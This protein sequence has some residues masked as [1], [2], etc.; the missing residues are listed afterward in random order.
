MND[1]NL[2]VMV[3]A[4]VTTFSG[5]TFSS[6]E[7]TATW[8]RKHLGAAMKAYG[9][10]RERRGEQKQWEKMH[11]EMNDGIDAAIA[12]IEKKTEK[13][14]MLDTEAGFIAGLNFV[15]KEIQPDARTSQAEDTK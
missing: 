5:T 14:E 12:R 7:D 11:K 3:E 13:C 9:D 2:E 6:W 8:M 15:R 1:T 10:E 4:L